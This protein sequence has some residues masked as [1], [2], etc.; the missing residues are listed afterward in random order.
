MKKEEYELVPAKDEIQNGDSSS[1]KGF[2]LFKKKAR[3]IK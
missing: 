2:R 1:H 3:K